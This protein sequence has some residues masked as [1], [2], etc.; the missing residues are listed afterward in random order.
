MIDWPASRP[1][2]RFADLS[3]RW[4]VHQGADCFAGSL[5]CS[6]TVAWLASC[7]PHGID[8]STLRSLF[9]SCHSSGTRP[10]GTVRPSF[11]SVPFQLAPSL[12]RNPVSP[13]DRPT[14]RCVGHAFLRAVAVSVEFCFV[15]FAD[16]PSVRLLGLRSASGAAPW[17]VGLLMASRAGSLMGVAVFTYACRIAALLPLHRCLVGHRLAAW[18]LRHWVASKAL[19]SPFA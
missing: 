15:R 11:C 2:P 10:L 8:C 9:R 7:L 16:R 1:A 13:A 6:S 17:F 5:I 4:F 18:R 3:S 19:S 14:G 12:L